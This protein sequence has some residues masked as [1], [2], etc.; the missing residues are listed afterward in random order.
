MALFSDDKRLNETDFADLAA[1]YA[2]LKRTRG[3][4]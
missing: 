3:T 1:C 4:P 2:T